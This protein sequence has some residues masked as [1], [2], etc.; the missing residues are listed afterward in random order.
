MIIKILAARSSFERQCHCWQQKA[1]TSLTHGHNISLSV[2][3]K[4]HTVLINH[5]AIESLATHNPHH[6]HCCLRQ[7]P[8]GD[9]GKRA[10]SLEAFV[11]WWQVLVLSDEFT[12]HPHH[13]GPPCH[14]ASS[15]NSRDSGRCFNFSMPWT[16]SESC[17]WLQGLQCQLALGPSGTHNHHSYAVSLA[18]SIT[19]CCIPGG[20]FG[21]RKITPEHMVC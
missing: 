8:A 15:S 7:L 20:S 13:T 10:G 1:T 11:R 3:G 18:T 17:Q 4:S 16:D 21:S 6:Q 12:P 19:L 5:C 2:G 9:M 14:P